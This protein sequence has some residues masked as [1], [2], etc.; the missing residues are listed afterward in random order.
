MRV[1]GNHPWYWEPL[2]AMENGFLEIHGRHTFTSARENCRAERPR[3]QSSRMT[4]KLSRSSSAQRN[5]CDLMRK[6]V[7]GLRSTV[8]YWQWFTRATTRNCLAQQ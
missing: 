3:A 5:V 2:R 6:Q 4:C 7:G 8:T 1:C